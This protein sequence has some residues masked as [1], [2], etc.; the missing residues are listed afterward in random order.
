[1]GAPTGAPAILPFPVSALAR[2]RRE[3]TYVRN[4]SML[5]K[6]RDR[7]ARDRGLSPDDHVDLACR[8]ARMHLERL[9]AVAIDLLDTNDGDSDLEANGDELDGTAGE[10]DFCEHAAWFG[11]P[12]CP[13]SDPGGGSDDEIGP[14]FGERA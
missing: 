13:L 1:M 5:Q 9:I 4:N 2:A 11:E 10:D 12:G 6:W 3:L 8:A 14:L 7:V